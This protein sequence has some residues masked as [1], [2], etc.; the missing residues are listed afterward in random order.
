MAR[1]NG[2][3]IRNLQRFMTKEG[4]MWNAT[5][6][7]EGI[8]IGTW[9]N[10]S[11]GGPDLFWLD[12][13]KYD[14]HKLMDEF[15]KKRPDCEYEAADEIMVDL[16]ELTLAEKEYKKIT[17]RGGELMLQLTDQYHC[18]MIELPNEDKGLTDEEIIE[19]EKE[20][21]AV[22]KKELKEET[23]INKHEIRIYRGFGDFII[24]D[25]IDLDSIRRRVPRKG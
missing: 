5:L 6:Y 21:I 4:P 19:K 23:D 13:D 18:I 3:S 11:S 2:V 7:L 14:T 20:I 9:S 24:G 17:K 15:A 8:R 12:V 16:V 22:K 25:S 1:L 10:D